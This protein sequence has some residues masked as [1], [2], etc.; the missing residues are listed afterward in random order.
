M[1]LVAGRQSRAR[2]SPSG[3]ALSPRS[4][5]TRTVGSASR[6]PSARSLQFRVRRIDVGE[7]ENIRES[8]EPAGCSAPLVLRGLKGLQDAAG[9]E[10]GV[11]VWHDVTQAGVDAFA[12]VTGDRNPIHI[13]T[14]TG[15]T[16]PFG[17]TI[18]HGL[19]TLSLGPQFNYM[20]YE[21]EDLGVA[22]NYGYDRIRFP[23]PL[24]IPS[25]VRMRLRL[26]SVQETP[27]GAQATF[28]QT[29]EREHGDRPV[30]VAT[31]L[32]RF[33]ADVVG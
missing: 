25:R 18:A 11:S 30:C 5:P 12:E 13:D 29:F 4:V 2:A 19:Y 1:A 31:F 15:A 26:E 8:D 23:A 24:P 33:V 3:F 7:G 10:L 32:L 14:S 28:T 22:L 16:S 27:G 20:L 9:R 17:T 21:V 6:P